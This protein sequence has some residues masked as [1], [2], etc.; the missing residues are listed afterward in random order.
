MLA[1]VPASAVLDSAVGG[2]LRCAV[3]SLAQV[4]VQ[5]VVMGV[6]FDAASGGTAAPGALLQAWADCPRPG[7]RRAAA[8][9]ATA[10]QQPA[11]LRGLQASPS[12]TPLP[13]GAPGFRVTVTVRVPADAA[14]EGLTG[15]DT[16]AS[17][18]ARALAV[19]VSLASGLDVGVSSPTGVDSTSPLWPFYSKLSDVSNVP[20]SAMAPRAY[21]N[22]VTVP[23]TRDGG[24]AA[25]GSLGGGAIA[26]I[27]IGVVAGA[28]LIA[29][30]GYY[31]YWGDSEQLASA[32]GGLW[33][34]MFGAGGDGGA[35]ITATRTVPRETLRAAVVGRGGGGLAQ[36]NAGAREGAG[37]G[38][39]VTVMAMNPLLLRAAS[40]AAAAGGGGGAAWHG[41]AAGAMFSPRTHSIATGGFGRAKPGG[42]LVTALPA[43]GSA[44]LA[45]TPHSTGRLGAATP[46]GALRAGDMST[47]YSSSMGSETPATTASRRGAA[48]PMSPFTAAGRTVA[49]RGAATSSRKGGAGV[50]RLD[51]ESSPPLAFQPRR[52]GRV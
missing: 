46:G 51:L 38:L 33:A 2:S 9:A 7:S 5:N 12:P 28:G 34:A 22:A 50:G 19:A 17:I 44:A 15:L 48:S 30:A 36:P 23:A 26:G 29:A 25:A 13:Y 35:P 8:A 41:G 42:G 40:R 27:V 4:D 6:V 37:V 47:F 16:A 31:L 39:P 20:T 3:A 52:G 1:G 43:G 49:H 10:A 18:T 32:V 21:L 45:G 24:G 11:R 14:S